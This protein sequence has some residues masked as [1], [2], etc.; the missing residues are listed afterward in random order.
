M[1]SADKHHARQA[2]IWRVTYEA[3]G[4]RA[5]DRVDEIIDAEPGTPEGTELEVLSSLIAD[6]EEYAV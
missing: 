6:V 5:Y 3:V 1:R 2:E 4:K